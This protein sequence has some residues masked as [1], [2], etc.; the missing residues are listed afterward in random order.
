MGSACETA[1]RVN[2]RPPI[3]EKFSRLP[4]PPPR[5]PYDWVRFVPFMLVHVAC[6]GVLWIGARPI[7]WVICA[8][9]YLV[10]TFGVMAGYH[11]YFSHR[12]FKTGRVF[13]FVLAFVAETTGQKGVLWWAAHHRNHHKFSDLPW[14]WHSPVQ[15]GFWHSHVGWIA[16]RG[17]DVTDYD[18]VKDF[19]RFPEIQWLNRNWY[20]PPVLLGFAVTAIFG[21]SALFAGF[22]VSTVLTWHATFLVNSLSHVVGKRR[23]P[24]SDTSRNHWLIAIITLGEGWHNNHH[25]CMNSVKQ[26][27]YWW[28]FDSTYYALRVLSWFGLVWDLRLPSATILADG[29]ARDAAA[30]IAAR[31]TPAVVAP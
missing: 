17:T 19:A 9:L 1:N 4:P 2:L 12:A 5:A 10:R 6:L 3:P 31:V 13:Q 22:F 30:R 24:T 16:E 29:R 20:L 8:V 27:F 11:R 15:K 23:F 28:E 18:R 21:W 25:H 14:D 7:D 26:G